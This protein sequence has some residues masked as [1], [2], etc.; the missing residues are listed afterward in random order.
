MRRKTAVLLVISLLLFALSWRAVRPPLPHLPNSDLYTHLSVARHLAAGEGF[1]TDIVYPVS[2]T[3]PFATRLPQPLL[4]RQPGYPVLLLGPTWLG[5]DD[6]DRI[7]GFVADLQLLLMVLAAALGLV[8]ARRADGAEVVPAWWLVLLLNP[9]LGFT[10]G[11]G[12]VEIPTALVLL[13][14]WWRM[15]PAI[16]AASPSP[17]SS[18]SAVAD[19][20]L[21]AILTLFRL[22]LVWIPALWWVAARRRAGL[23]CA[24]LALA[25][26]LLVTAPWA[27]R[28]ARLTGQPFFSL[29]MYAEHL[30]ETSAWPDYSIYRSLSPE[31]LTTTL[32]TQPGLLLAKA[33]AGARFFAS[34]LGRWLPW[35][36]WALAGTLALWSNRRDLRCWHWRTPLIVAGL[37]AILLMT[38]YTIF[39]HTLRHLVVVLLVFTL[40]LCLW[41]GVQL[42][43][44]WPRGRPVWRGLVLMAGMAAGHL[45]TPLR[46]PGWEHA[47]AEARQAA[48]ALTAG[49]QAADAL[50]PGPLFCD[51]SALL[52]YT[53]RVGVWAPLDAE[54]TATIRRTVPQMARAEVLWL[55]VGSYGPT[56]NPEPL[57]E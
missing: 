26:W 22:D 47:L 14:L 4:H 41:L 1:V 44:L 10:A 11:W 54:V 49:I 9:V 5:G 2:L 51:S 31:A 25:T 55:H 48:T 24:L 46:L 52:W 34:N 56:G 15:R 19:G 53:E 27:V 8:I 6:P 43:R 42:R 36:V 7:L 23:H 21:S 12:L 16:A 3:F 17:L 57:S 30:K 45:V 40:E 20:L 35:S 38:M 33:R 50:P 37:T 32:T 13:M 28:T 18:A 29:Q 39:S